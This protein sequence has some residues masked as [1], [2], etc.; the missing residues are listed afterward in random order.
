M[1]DQDI[2]K[3]ELP[4]LKDS[5]ITR[6]NRVTTFF[7]FSSFIHFGLFYTL[8]LF[9]KFASIPETE[10]DMWPQRPSLCGHFE[11]YEYYN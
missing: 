9:F 7:M 8:F 5:F 10:L 3:F 4:V 6:V 1:W 2:L 11:E